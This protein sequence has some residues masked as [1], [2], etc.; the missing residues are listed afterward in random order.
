MNEKPGT[1]ENE[2]MHHFVLCFALFHPSRFR[3]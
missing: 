1:G 2:D 3:F